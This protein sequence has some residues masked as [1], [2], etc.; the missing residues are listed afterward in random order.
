MYYDMKIFNHKTSST[1]GEKI[2]YVLYS[3]NMH[4]KER[5]DKKKY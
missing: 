1:I 4:L 2:M 3:A 5:N